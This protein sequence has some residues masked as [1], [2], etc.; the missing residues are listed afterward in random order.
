[1]WPGKE[2]R[3][4]GDSSTL[5]FTRFFLTFKDI[6]KEAISLMDSQPYGLSLWFP[7]LSLMVVTI[8]TSG[9]F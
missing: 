4:D 1:M 7:G 6:I 5:N 8:A 9:T 3:D 2:E